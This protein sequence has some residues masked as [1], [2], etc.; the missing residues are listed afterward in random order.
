MLT[1][2]VVLAKV[3]ILQ[4]HSRDFDKFFRFVSVLACNFRCPPFFVS[5]QKTV[6]LLETR[7]KLQGM[8]YCFSM[9]LYTHALLYYACRLQPVL[10]VAL[11]CRTTT[12][13]QYNWLKVMSVN[14]CDFCLNILENEW[15]S[16]LC[17][18]LFN[19]NNTF[20]YVITK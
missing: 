8:V 1:F 12:K 18:I 6:N 16:S 3:H 11:Y 2:L 4:L 19:F 15:Q 14:W 10:K 20:F 17:Q 7:K 9:V 5:K 13:T